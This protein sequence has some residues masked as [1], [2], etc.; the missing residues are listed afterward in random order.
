MTGLQ[1]FTVIHVVISL[2]GIGSGLI[3]LFGFLAGMRL[4]AWNTAFLASTITTSVTGFLFPFKGIT[5]GIL[6]GIVSL[7]VLALALVALRRHCARTYIASVSAA[8]FFNVL[9]L[10]V[11]VFEKVPALHRYAPKRNEPIVAVIQLIALVIFVGLA[12]ASIRRS[13]HSPQAI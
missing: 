2:L 4:R 12:L 1:L 6:V 13:A 3:V 7:I 11:Q 8:E 5:P 10:I 9:V